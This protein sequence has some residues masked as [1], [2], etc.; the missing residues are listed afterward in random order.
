MPSLTTSVPALGNSKHNVPV[1]TAISH[2]GLIGLTDH[3]KNYR[4]KEVVSFILVYLYNETGGIETTYVIDTLNRQYAK[5]NDKLNIDKFLNE[6]GFTPQK[7][8]GGGRRR[9]SKRHRRSTK[10]RRSTRKN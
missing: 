3:I 9:H 10:R 7:K 1:A 5:D 8:A 4:I 2:A 6:K